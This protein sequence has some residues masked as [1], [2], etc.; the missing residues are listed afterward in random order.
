MPALLALLCACASP[1]VVEQYVARWT[2]PPAMIT[3]G[4]FPDAPLAGNGDLGI[5]LGGDSDG[6][7]T[8]HLG[9][10]QL[11]GLRE[12]GRQSDPGFTG[13]TVF[14]RRLGLGYLRLWSPTL[15]NATFSA[16]QQLASGVVSANLTAAS[17]QTLSVRAYVA[18]DENVLVAEVGADPPLEVHITTQALP[19]SELCKG[20]LCETMD[21][22]IA[23]GVSDAG[24][25]RGPVLWSQRQPLGLSSPKPISVAVA[26]ASVDGPSLSGCTAD[27]GAGAANCTATVAAQLTL[28]SA[29]ISNFDLCD[30][31]HGCADPLNATLDRA[32]LA[33]TNGSAAAISSDNLRFWRG[34]WNSSWVSMPGDPTL[35]RFYYGTSYMIG[36][37]SREGKVAAGLCR[38]LHAPQPVPSCA[39]GTPCKC[40]LHRLPF[41]GGP[42][43]QGVL[44][45]NS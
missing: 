27:S 8:C 6:S 24:G 26:T 2:K 34:Y 31:P 20:S 18:P 30:T 11:W 12:Y 19:L 45:S 4:H 16:A 44:V 32:T 42:D 39:N 23:A 37:A 10:N 38:N 35:E 25:T 33:T 40:H 15:A 7:L 1:P 36:A 9:L 3:K 22:R 28:A 29:V 21:G 41:A 5:S 14:P 17:G 43:Q 13:D